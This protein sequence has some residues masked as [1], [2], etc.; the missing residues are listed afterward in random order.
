V[1]W[2]ARYQADGRGAHDDYPT[3][4][5][6]HGRLRMPKHQ[7]SGLHPRKVSVFRKAGLP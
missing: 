3:E 1:K 5:Q 4:Y 2:L 7:R 6:L